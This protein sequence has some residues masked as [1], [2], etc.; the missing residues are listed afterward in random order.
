MTFIRPTDRERLQAR[1]EQELEGEVRLVLFVQPPTGLYIPG[2]EEPQTG[3]QT[4]QLLREVA[5]LSPRIRLEVHNPRLAPELAQRY[6]I[7]RTPALIVLPGTGD[8][9]HGTSADPSE[10]AG[11][12][13]PED[14][15][16]DTQSSV[17]RPQSWNDGRVRFF[18][19]PSGYEFAS[20]VEAIVDTSRG[21]TRLSDAT[22]AALAALRAPLHFQVFVTPT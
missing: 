13:A 8:N 12:H 10:P 5:A 16:P 1:F 7:E 17:S 18:G 3:R 19:M 11:D 22:R 21:R 15:E 4:E 6:Q 20:L 2:R 14:A 9:G